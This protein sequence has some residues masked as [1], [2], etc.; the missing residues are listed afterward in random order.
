MALLDPISI[1]ITRS[2]NTSETFSGRPANGEAFGITELVGFEFPEVEVFTAA[3]G[4]GDGVFF[5]GQRLNGRTVEIHLK[6]NERY[7]DDFYLAWQLLKNFFN[8]AHSFKI[9]VVYT[10]YTGLT[11]TRYLNDCRILAADYHM[12]NASEPNPELIVQ[13]MSPNPFFEEASGS[14]Q[15]FYT[16][17]VALTYTYIGDY[18][19]RPVLIFKCTNAGD[20]TVLS[21]DVTMNGVQWSVGTPTAISVG[22]QITLDPETM[23]IGFNGPPDPDQAGT[24]NVI[25]EAWWLNPGTNAN[26]FT[27]DGNGCTFTFSVSYTPRYLGI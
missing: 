21:F 8:P 3:K 24:A 13:M 4:L 7:P 16:D 15:I 1:T 22:D 2:D 27:I 6:Q 10:P 23:G 25:Y 9:K 12:I 17:N 19:T 14:E 5:T 11:Q 20:G 18:K 26:T